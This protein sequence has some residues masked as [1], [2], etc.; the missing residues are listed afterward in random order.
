MGRILG[1]SLCYFESANQRE[2]GWPSKTNG[3]IYL[4]SIHPEELRVAART[5]CNCSWK[6]SGEPLDPQT[7]MKT[8]THLA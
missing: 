8:N 6:G 3:M 1:F 2:L 7:H 4:N 5:Q